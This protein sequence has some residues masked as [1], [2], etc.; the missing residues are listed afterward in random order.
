MFFAPIAKPL[1]SVQLNIDRQ[2]VT[3]QKGTF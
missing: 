1:I 2:T 3:L